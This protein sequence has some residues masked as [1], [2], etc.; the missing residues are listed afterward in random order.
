MPKIVSMK[1]LTHVR[2][3]FAPKFKKHGIYW[4]FAFH[5]SN[6]SIPI[7]ISKM[8]FIILLLPVG[9]QLIPKLHDQTHPLNMPILILTSKNFYQIFTTC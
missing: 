9:P 5:N 7:P 8:I 1:Y 4:N 3:K 6:I 2:S